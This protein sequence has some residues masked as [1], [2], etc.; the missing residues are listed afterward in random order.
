MAISAV[1]PIWFLIYYGKE[2]VTKRKG[3]GAVVG[4]RRA[5]RL[6]AVVFPD[7]AGD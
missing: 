7:C 5:C 4:V 6:H 1:I 2:E 3:W